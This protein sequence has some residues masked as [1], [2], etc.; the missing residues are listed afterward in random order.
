MAFSIKKSI[1][2]LQK[3]N[4]GDTNPGETNSEIL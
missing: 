2:I 1:T 4:G 3:R